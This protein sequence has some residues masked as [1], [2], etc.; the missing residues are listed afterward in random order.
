MTLPLW[1]EDSGHD[2]VMSN[3]KWVGSGVIELVLP[4]VLTSALLK[5]IFQ[6]RKLSKRPRLILLYLSAEG[7]FNQT[8]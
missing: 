8:L 5:S 1:N 7:L 2:L 4:D 6:D 3:L